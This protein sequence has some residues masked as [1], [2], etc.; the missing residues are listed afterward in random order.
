MGKMTN[1]FVLKVLCLPPQEFRTLL[2]GIYYGQWSGNK[3]I[4]WGKLTMAK[5]PS[6]LKV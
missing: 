3:G 4:G 1:V 5:K 6:P 2:I